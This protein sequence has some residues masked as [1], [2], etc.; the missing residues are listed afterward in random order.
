MGVEKI[1]FD[2]LKSNTKKLNCFGLLSL[3]KNNKFLNQIH[4]FRN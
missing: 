1:L 2:T 4:Y 3:F